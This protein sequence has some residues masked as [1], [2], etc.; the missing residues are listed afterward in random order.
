MGL[1]I[2]ARGSKYQ[3]FE[4]SG[5]TNHI[6]SISFLVPKMLNIGYMEPLGTRVFVE[7]RRFRQ[8]VKCTCAV[9][10]RV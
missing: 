1:G 7:G 5:S 2:Y 8:V 6:L 4:V 3:I 10:V 9:E